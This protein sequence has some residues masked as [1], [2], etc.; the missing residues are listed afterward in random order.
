VP[1]PQKV[2]KELKKPLVKA[3]PQLDH[4]VTFQTS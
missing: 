2:A 3:V 4:V 1:K